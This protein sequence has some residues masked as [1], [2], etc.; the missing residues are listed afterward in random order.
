M[1]HITLT[2]HMQTSRQD[3]KAEESEN[4]VPH[5]SD[6]D[7]GGDEN[8]QGFKI[9]RWAVSNQRFWWY[10][11]CRT[12]NG[13]IGCYYLS[14]ISTTACLSTLLFSDSV[15]LSCQHQ[16]AELSVHFTRSFQTVLPLEAFVLDT[17]ISRGLHSYCGT[18]HDVCNLTWCL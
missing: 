15:F 13:R 17:S 5:V 10:K 11:F 8:L 12:L 14:T 16:D 18:W 9:H 7:S 2:R 4:P 1:E 6:T 3:R